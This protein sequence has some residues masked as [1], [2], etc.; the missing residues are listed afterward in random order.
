MGFEETKLFLKN[1]MSSWQTARI[2]GVE[3]K[4]FLESLEKTYS[5]LLASLGGK[6]ELVIGILEKELASGENIFFEL[7]EKVIQPITH[8][9]KIDIE[10]IIFHK[11]VSKEELIKFTSF[12]ITPVE[13][14][15]HASQEY[16]SAAGI[17]N[18]EVGKIKAPGEDSLNQ[19]KEKE[20]E[21]VHYK[22]LLDRLSLLLG[23]L[24][25]GDAVDSLGLK[26]IAN[27]IMDNLKGGYQIFSKLRQV[28]SYDMATFV[29]L[30]NVSILAIY[31]SNKLGF[32]RD[33]CLDIGA[34]GLFHDIG[35]LYIAKKIIQKAD[36]LDQ[37]EFDKVKGH[38]V[39]GA[40][41]LLRHIDSLTI[42]PVVV[43]FEHHLRYDLGGYPKL[44]FPHKIHIASSIVAICDVYDALTQRRS[45]KRDYSPEKIY[46]LM[47]KDKNKRFDP[48]LLDSFF[49]AMGVWPRKTIVRLEDGRIGIVR[50]VNEND[51]FS[52]VI[53]VVDGGPKELIDLKVKKETKIKHSLNPLGEGKDYVD[54]T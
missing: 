12:L 14:I 53:E 40:E 10:R 8:L 19:S 16:V 41:I 6:N 21:L 31:F 46:E 35:K 49:K 24:I 27:D 22:V 9:K 50:Q 48:K 51:I 25:D 37:E 38:T 47:I 13:E 1:F 32:S 5:T 36:K 29:H 52:P 42:L 39:L 43:A 20:N 17:K 26:Y 33:D 2:Y 3:H 45:Y 7:S 28:K 15:N 23:G 54:L 18:I 4:L 30:L 34:A 11:G 44:F